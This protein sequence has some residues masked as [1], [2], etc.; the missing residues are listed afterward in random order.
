MELKYLPLPNKDL[1]IMMQDAKK[2]LKKAVNNQVA[3]GENEDGYIYETVTQENAQAEV[4]YLV[5]QI[6]SQMRELKA[7]N[8]AVNAQ[9]EDYALKLGIDLHD[10]FEDYLK[11]RDKEEK[12]ASKMWDYK[13]E[14]DLKTT[15]KSKIYRG[16]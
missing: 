13:T 16:V 3:V 6:A 5:D 4:G 11:Y 7:T 12:I 1:A 2:R 8:R 14:L 10:I 9:A 15:R